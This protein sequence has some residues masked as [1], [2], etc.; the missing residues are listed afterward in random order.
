MCIYV[1]KTNQI[2]LKLHVF[3]MT[4]WINLSK[5]PL[6]YSRNIFCAAKTVVQINV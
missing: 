5:L 2:L 4:V 6:Q 1:I 3:C